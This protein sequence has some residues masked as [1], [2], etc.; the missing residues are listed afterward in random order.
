MKVI[1]ADIVKGRYFESLEQ[2]KLELDDYI[3]WFNHF[4]IQGKL[5]YLSP[6]EY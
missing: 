2:L 5:G 3:H 1:K 6:L 4:K